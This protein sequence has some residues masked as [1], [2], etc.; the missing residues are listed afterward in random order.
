MLLF[1]NTATHFL[2]AQQVTSTLTQVTTDLLQGEARSSFNWRTISFIPLSNQGLARIGD[3][4]FPPC[5]N[6]SA[7]WP[8][9]HPNPTPG[10]QPLVYEC[11]YCYDGDGE[12]QC[13][14]KQ[15]G[16]GSDD[17][18][19]EI[20][21]IGG[22]GDVKGA[23]VPNDNNDDD[24][25][26]E[27]PPPP[28]W[29]DP[30]DWNPPPPPNDQG[31]GIYNPN[32][33]HG[34][35]TNDPDKDPK[36]PDKPHDNLSDDG[37]NDNVITPLK[38][39]IEPEKEDCIAAD[40]AK[41][42]ELTNQLDA[43]ENT[44]EMQDLRAQNDVRRFEVGFSINPSSSGLKAQDY[45]NSGQGRTVNTLIAAYTLAD[46]HSHPEK[47]SSNTTN[48]MSPSAPD[49]VVLASYMQNKTATGKRFKMR[50]S[51]VIAGG[52]NKADYAINIEDTTQ[53]INFTDNPHNAI[54]SLI[55][56]DGKLN[57]WKGTD[58]DKTT[59]R[60][61]FVKIR[62]SLKDDGY[63]DA[64]AEYYAQVIMA[65][66]LGMGIAA[67]KKVDGKFRK[68]RFEKSTDGEHYK[69]SICNN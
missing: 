62:K 55:Y 49:I 59:L 23:D 24:D 3:P 11:R 21:T 31:G 53:A 14:Q 4:E 12:T 19:D 34:T 40:T 5:T 6:F 47:D 51:Y 17:K 50:T 67:Y 61:Q 52:S 68:L 46:V 33:P 38:K 28:N 57:S 60:G 44:P 29:D 20:I 66:N 63:S 7:S 2:K 37:K 65:S 10:G 27:P 8:D 39:I 1:F 64:N 54:D 25:D 35:P 32:D 13:I 41:G 42:R 26:W 45:I 69:L 18:K 16:Q 22:G 9:N 56:N 43:V 15:S 48:V 58:E 36:G 30:N